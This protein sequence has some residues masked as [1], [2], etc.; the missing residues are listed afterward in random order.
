MIRNNFLAASLASA[1]LG[2]LSTPAVA[3]GNVVVTAGAFGGAATDGADTV[4]K[5]AGFSGGFDGSVAV[6]ASG[7][8]AQGDVQYARH[9]QQDAV[10]GGLHL[11]GHVAPNAYVGFYGAYA[12]G[13]V[14]PAVDHLRGGGEFVLDF[15][16]FRLTGVAG[17]EDVDR[18]SVLVVAGPPSDVTDS[19]GSDAEFFDMVDLRYTAS[20]ALQMFAGHRYVGGAHAVAF[21]ADWQASDRISFYAEGRAGECDY[22]AGWVGVRIRFGGAKSD[23]DQS[24]LPSRLK[25]EL[26]G[27]SNTRRRV[28][29]PVAPPPGGG[30]TCGGYAA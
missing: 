6:F 20:G 19:Y 8:V 1:A 22:N 4:A 21:G 11:G 12:T 18:K 25:D 23:T 10:A 15:G 29:T 26:F 30:G 5:D 9:L 16:A 28:V 3:E 27:A 2:A 17:V 7:L 24:L 14:D 13:T